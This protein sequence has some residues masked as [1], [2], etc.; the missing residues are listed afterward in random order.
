M[1]GVSNTIDDTAVKIL[2]LCN[3]HDVDME[4][5]YFD[6]FVIYKMSKKTSSGRTCK[7]SMQLNTTD[8]IANNG[9]DMS[10]ILD[11]MLERFEEQVKKTEDFKNDNT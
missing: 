11:K 2:E 10:Y 3:D 7:T 4:T 6:T 9:C 8:L 5:F 1:D